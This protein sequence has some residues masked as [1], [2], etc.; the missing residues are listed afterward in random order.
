MKIVLSDLA[1]A[2]LKEIYSYHK[3]VASVKTAT[4]IRSSIVSAIKGLLQFHAK[5]QLEEFLTPLNKQ[6]R[7]EV[8]GNYKIIYFLEDET[9]YVTDIFDT[10]QNPSKMGR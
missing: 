4:K 5:N 1:K 3:K 6:H 8:V 2:N 9:I 7:R 10:R